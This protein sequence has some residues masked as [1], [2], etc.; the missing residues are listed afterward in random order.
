MLHN[1]LNA[2]GGA[3]HGVRTT[4]EQSRSDSELPKVV[5]DVL[6]RK[7]SPL[8]ACLCPEDGVRCEAIGIGQA[9]KD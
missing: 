3:I 9:R 5:V 6:G 4:F 7:D 1:S 8:G 2:D